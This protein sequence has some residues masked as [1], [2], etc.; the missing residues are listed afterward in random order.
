MCDIKQKFDTASKYVSSI[1]ELFL[2]PKHI[3]D[4]QTR[5][6][7]SPKW[8]P[9]LS[10]KKTNFSVKTLFSYLNGYHLIMRSLQEEQK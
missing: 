3:L 8:S 2:F 9:K 6:S 5:V 4:F 7:L 1:F 10:R